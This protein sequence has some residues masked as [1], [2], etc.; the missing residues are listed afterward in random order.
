MPSPCGGMRAPRT[1]PRRAC[2]RPGNA[3]WAATPASGERSRRSV[4]AGHRPVGLEHDPPVGRLEPVLARRAAPAAGRARKP[5]RKPVAQID[6][7]RPVDARARRGSARPATPARAARPSARPGGYDGASSGPA[8]AA[9]SSAPVGGSREPAPRE[10]RRGTLSG[11]RSGSRRRTETTSRPAASA[12]SHSVAAAMPAPTTATRRAYSCGSYACTA[13]ASPASSAGT[14]RPGCP[15]ASSTWRNVPWPSS[16]KPAVD[17]RT[18]SMR[19]TRRLSSQPLARAPR[20]RARGTPRPSGG[21]G[22]AREATSGRAS[23]ASSASRRRAPGTTSAGSGRRSRS[24]SRAAGSPP[25]AAARPPRGRGRAAKTAISPGSSPPWRSVT[26]ATKPASP[27]PTMA[28][29][30]HFTEPASSPCTK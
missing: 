4:S 30:D 5:R 16:S 13:R 12:F 27:P 20:R 17:A 23:D 21:S 19:T 25:P 18:A 15:G 2:R 24:A 6:L 26:Y 9:R 3:H 14:L 11:R 22:R 7:L 10:E 8:R 1:S 29:R 28:T